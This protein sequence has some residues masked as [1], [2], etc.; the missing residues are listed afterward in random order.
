MLPLLATTFILPI[1]QRYCGSSCSLYLFSSSFL[2]VHISPD[3]HLHLSTG[4][5]FS[6]LILVL[7]LMT[8]PRLHILAS[9]FSSFIPLDL[10]Q[11]ATRYLIFFH[12]MLKSRPCNIL[13]GQRSHDIYTVWCSKGSFLKIPSRGNRLK[14]KLTEI[15]AEAFW[16]FMCAH[17]DPM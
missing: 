13:G 4:F 1:C 9:T 2:S 7:S 15:L 10:K 8:I 17:V 3:S 5:S 11:L 16:T 6:T 12:F 14:H